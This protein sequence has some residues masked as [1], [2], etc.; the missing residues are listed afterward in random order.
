MP[1]WIEVPLSSATK[2]ALDNRALVLKACN[3][4]PAT[5]LVTVDDPSPKV[6]IHVDY[7]DEQVCESY[8]TSMISEKGRPGEYYFDAGA[9]EWDSF[10]CRHRHDESSCKCRWPIYHVGQDEAVFKQFAMPSF[11]WN[12]KGITKLRQKTEGM[13]IMVS[14]FF[15]EW[16]GFGMQLT[17][18]EVVLVNRRRREESIE[19]GEVP[20]QEIETGASPGLIFFEYGN[21]K[22]KQ[23]YWDGVKFQE[24][25]IDFIDVIEILYPGMQILLEVDHSSGH[26]KE[27]SDGLMVNAMGCNW[28]GKA[29]PKRDSVIEEGCLGP[30]LPEINGRTLTIGMTQRMV[31]SADDPPP[32]NDKKALPFD[33]PMTEEETVKEKLKRSK[34]SHNIPVQSNAG[35][36]LQEDIHEAPFVVQ[37]YVGKNKGIFQVS[38]K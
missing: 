8:R 31:F 16:R 37:G 3:L 10:P 14:G 12:V 35:E 18:E 22:G 34:K 36:E 24:Q 5:P 4:N 26:L 25:C 21:G 38:G 28:G 1:V 30:A 19:S 13:G 2:V 7:L 11:C 27:Q 29:T 20:R 6:K 15:D 9:P 17:D 33:R 23:G 32:F